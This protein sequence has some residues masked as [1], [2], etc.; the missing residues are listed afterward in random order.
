MFTSTKFNWHWNNKQVKSRWKKCYLYNRTTVT[1][2][3]QH[4]KA[5]KLAMKFAPMVNVWMQECSTVWTAPVI[6]KC[7]NAAQWLWTCCS[8]QLSN[9]RP[10][11]NLISNQK[12]ETNT[13][14]KF[15]HAQITRTQACLSLPVQ[16]LSEQV[17]INMLIVS[18]QT[19]R[20]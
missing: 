13:N 1:T 20:C 3:V 17:T 6:N 15:V 4:Y 2:N 9:V 10:N 5:I 12:E 7:M 14:T 18:S 8:T 11:S 19:L 16:F